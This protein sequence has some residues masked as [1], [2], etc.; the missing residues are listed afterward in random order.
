MSGTDF[1]AVAEL[2]RDK[3]LAMVL[4]FTYLAPDH[5]LAAVERMAAAFSNRKTGTKS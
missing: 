3:T 4:Q 1:R 5:K 2:L